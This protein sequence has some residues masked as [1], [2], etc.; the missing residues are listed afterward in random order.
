MPNINHE[1]QFPLNRGAMKWCNQFYQAKRLEH[2][3]LGEENHGE[4]ILVVDDDPQILKLV[5][6][7]L[8]KK[9]SVFTAETPGDAVGLVKLC[10]GEIQ[11][12]ISDVYMSKMNGCELSEQLILMEPA[13]NVLFMSGY[14]YSVLVGRGMLKIGEHF[15]QKPFSIKNLYVKVQAALV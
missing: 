10:P 4:T 5:R 7:M 3:K 14:A 12:L 15:I 2:L 6:A 11:L 1:I 8:E 9:Y 13:L